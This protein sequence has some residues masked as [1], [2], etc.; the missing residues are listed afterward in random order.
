MIKIKYF[1]IFPLFLILLGC[2]G[3]DDDL[4]PPLEVTISTSNE[5]PSYNEVY[6]ISWESN[7]SQCYAQ[8]LTGSWI[9]ELP[10]SG[11]QEFIAKREGFANYG[12]QCRQSINFASASVDLEV[13]KSF[14]NYFDFEDATVINAG[15]LA[16]DPGN[17]IEISDVS[18]SDFNQDFRLDLVFLI[19]EKM[20][21]SSVNPKFHVIVFY[22]ENPTLIDDENPYSYVQINFDD[23]VADK[24]V[25]GDFNSDASPDLMTFSSSHEE[26]LDKRGICFLTSS[27]DGLVLEDE[28]FL[29]NETVLSLNNVNVGTELAYDKNTDGYPDMLMMGNGGSTDMPFY[30]V[31]SESGPT[32]KL[33]ESF[34][35]LNP[36]TRE[37]GCNDGFNYLCNWISDNYIFKN[38]VLINADSDTTLDL[39]HSISTNDGGKFD[40]YNTRLEG[41]AYDFSQ[42]IENFINPSISEEDGYSILLQSYDA[43]LDGYPDLLNIERSDLTKTFKFSIYEKVISEDDDTTTSEISSINN[44]DFIEEFVFNDDYKFA[45]EILVFDVNRDGIR[46]IFAPYTELPLQSNSS[47]Y[48]KHF[49]AFER[50]LT[51]NDDETTTKEWIRQDFSELVGLD[52]QSVSN[53]WFDFDSDQDVDVILIIPETQEDLSIKYN[54]NIYLNNSLF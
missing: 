3:S 24:L 5:E 48:D 16:F 38:S 8:S 32:I 37:Q 7:A 25:L 44:G 41:N 36:Y 34:E 14:T 42:P 13:Q 10:T 30:V 31:T 49:L 21:Q 29:I 33:N 47:N 2:S 27:I 39:L 53:A 18:L 4:A 9:G 46:D 54:F 26:S 19:K 22:G 1:F 23:C 40:L 28:E 20:N 51:V 15:S 43:N 35:S 50:S 45:N 52:S 17:S 11:S 12:I 6:T